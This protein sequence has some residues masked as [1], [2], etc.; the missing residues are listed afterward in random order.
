MAS[1][2]TI[3]IGSEQMF[4]RQVGASALS[5]VRGVNGSPVSEH[6]DGSSI[7]AL[8]FP[9]EVVEATLLTAVDRWRRR[10]GVARSDN[11]AAGVSRSLYDPSED[12]KDL[13][14]PYRRV[15]I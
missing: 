2:Q 6:A 3:L 1:G 8:Q 11:V 13:L 9:A 15:S 14:A 5:V 10:D 7:R 4:V 12:V